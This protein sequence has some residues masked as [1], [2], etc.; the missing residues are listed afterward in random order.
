MEVMVVLVVAVAVV[1]TEYRAWVVSLEAAAHQATQHSAL[2]VSAAS[3][4]IGLKDTNHEIRM[5]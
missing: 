2:A 3:F 1:I 4:S 5:D